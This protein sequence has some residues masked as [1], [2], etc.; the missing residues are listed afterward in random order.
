MWRGVRDGRNAA[1]VF[2][3]IRLVFYNSIR[4]FG[5]INALALSE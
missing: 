2:E 4:E 3:R 5:N 1:V